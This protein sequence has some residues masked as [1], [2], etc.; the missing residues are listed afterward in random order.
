MDG[1]CFVAVDWINQQAELQGKESVEIA[2]FDFRH[3]HG[4]TSSICL[5]L[6]SLPVQAVYMRIALIQVRIE[7]LH[8]N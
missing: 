7:T 6:E 3:G 1:F 5:Q 8:Y 2:A 4:D